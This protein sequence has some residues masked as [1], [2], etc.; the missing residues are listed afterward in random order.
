MAGNLAFT[1]PIFE[2]LVE[3]QVQMRVREKST[4]TLMGVHVYN[5]IICAM[6]WE[7]VTDT[8]NDYRM[9]QSIKTIQYLSTQNTQFW[10]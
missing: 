10:P 7:R 5:L 9:R 6:I 8:K 1:T 3:I 2:I 4:R